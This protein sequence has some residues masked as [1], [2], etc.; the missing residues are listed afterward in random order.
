MFRR[1]RIANGRSKHTSP[2][3]KAQ[4]YGMTDLQHCFDGPGYTASWHS[5]S[6]ANASFERI[7][8]FCRQTDP[9]C[10]FRYPGEL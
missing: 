3:Q 4:R 2:G 8:L 1:R 9:A 5:L 7:D 10:S 6:E